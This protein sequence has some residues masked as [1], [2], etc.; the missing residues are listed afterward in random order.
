MEAWIKKVESGEN[1]FTQVKI[2]DKK[3]SKLSQ[4]YNAMI[5]DQQDRVKHII[6]ISHYRKDANMLLP[7]TGGRVG[8][9]CRHAK[10]WKMAKKQLGRTKY[11][12]APISERGPWEDR[13]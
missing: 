2:S 1:T 4:E 7:L 11:T 9:L 13:F 3:F 12:T 10:K 8:G 6:K 5:A